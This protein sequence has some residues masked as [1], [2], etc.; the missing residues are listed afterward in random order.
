NGDKYTHVT[1]GSNGNIY[2]NLVLHD[3]TPNINHVGV[4]PTPP[5]YD[6][7]T[8]HYTTAGSTNWVKKSLYPLF[9]LQSGDI[10]MNDY[11]YYDGGT[12]NP[13][14]GPSVVPP[15][16]EIIA[17]T[18]SGS[19]ITATYPSFPQTHYNFY[20]HSTSGT[21]T[22]LFNSGYFSKFNRSNNKLFLWSWPNNDFRVYDVSANV[23][24]L[25]A[26]LTMNYPIYVVQIDNNDFVYVLIN[27]VLNKFDYTNNSY[28]P[29]AIA[30]FTNNNLISFVS[31]SHIGTNGPYT[32]DQCL[33]G[34]TVEENIYAL[35]FAS[36]TERKAHT[37]NF[38]AGPNS[39][40]A[41]SST[42][43]VANGNDIYIS[44]TTQANITIANTLIPSLGTDFSNFIVKLNLQT[45]FVLRTI[46]NV[47]SETE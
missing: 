7:F 4:T 41:P 36:M 47:T 11:N 24:T 13:T 28:T 37:N 25:I 30:G 6:E 27:G 38:L 46:K 12:G 1:R 44:G 32:S 43:Y 3:I 42:S 26:S 45:D 35:N 34:Q 22:L 10:Q 19:F 18:I 29:V 40:L 21:S 33:V 17:E 14:A 16:E 9:V 2:M 39:W 20:I 5:F 15:N 8:L 23:F 31:D